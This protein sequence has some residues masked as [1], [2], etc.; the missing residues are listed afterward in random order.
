MK[1]A[2]TLIFFFFLLISLTLFLIDLILKTEDAT[3]ATE[4]GGEMY[5]RL[6][7][8]QYT[9]NII[10]N[11]L[12]ALSL[13]LVTTRFFTAAKEMYGTKLLEQLSA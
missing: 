11:L 10:L 12:L 1:R 13:L 3:N 2:M 7:E 4:T 8:I 9:F 6:D 5:W